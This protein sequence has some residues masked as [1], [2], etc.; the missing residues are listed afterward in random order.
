M[1]SSS[2][3]S[4]RFVLVWCAGHLPNYEKWQYCAKVSHTGVLLE[5]KAHQED[6]HYARGA[7]LHVTPLW[8]W[9]LQPRDGEVMYLVYWNQINDG[10]VEAKHSL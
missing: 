1:S 8:R 7:V 2:I 10:V 3:C 4:I 5:N 6:I 9:G